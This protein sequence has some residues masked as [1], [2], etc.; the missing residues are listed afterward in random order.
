MGP[1]KLALLMAAM[2]LGS[3]MP[4]TAAEINPVA[5]RLETFF[6]CTGNSRVLNALTVQEAP[7]WDT[8]APAASVQDGA[9]CGFA[10]PGA[11][12]GTNQENVYDAVFKGSFTGNLDSL[13]LRLYDMGVGAARTGADQTLGIRLSIDGKSMFGTHTPEASPADL[14]LGEPVPVPSTATVTAKPSSVNS[15]VTNYVE[16]TVTGLG[17]MTEDGA[18]RYVHDLVV[19]VNSASEAGSMWV[20]DTTEVPSGITFNGAPAA[21]AVA[22]TTPGPA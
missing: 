5:A 18:G 20:L 10:D 17:F 6:H 4:A 13:T 11:R 3:V 16:L 1:K 15:G 19:T 8:T 2:L 14:V 22:A 7:S 12:T 9:G 21:A